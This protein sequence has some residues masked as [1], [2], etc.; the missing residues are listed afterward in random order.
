MFTLTENRVTRF[1]AKFEAS[2][3]E[4]LESGAVTQAQIDEANRSLDI[5]IVEFCAFQEQKS[6]AHAMGK[7]TFE[8]AQA[9]YSILGGSPEHF[10]RQPLSHKYTVTAMMA[11]LLR[12]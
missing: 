2:L 4:R 11:E 1:I 9:V 6:Y 10:N 12:K 7:I 3:K 8:E 5:D